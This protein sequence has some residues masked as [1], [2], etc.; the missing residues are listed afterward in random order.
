MGLGRDTPNLRVESE[1]I[2]YQFKRKNEIREG[3]VWK[4]DWILREKEY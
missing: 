4:K 1:N 2:R 3:V